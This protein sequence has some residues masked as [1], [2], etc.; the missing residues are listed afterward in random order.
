MFLGYDDAALDAGG[1][2]LADELGPR[3]RGWADLLAERGVAAF[4][5]TLTA[6]RGL[7]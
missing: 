5:E 6:E 4:L 7:P 2:D 3:L 1:D